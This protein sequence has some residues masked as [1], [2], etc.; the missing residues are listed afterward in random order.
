VIIRKSF[1]F[2]LKINETT[3]NKLSQVAG[4]CRFVWNKALALQIERL[5][6]KEKLLP[7]TQISKQLTEW[8]KDQDTLFLSET[9]FDSQQQKLRDLDR[10]FR[11]GF[12]KERDKKI[13]R[14]KK[15]G[16]R[17]SFRCVG[18]KQFSLNGNQVRIP[19]VGWIRFRKSREIEG[20]PKNITVSKS[21]EHWF[22]S[23]QTEI[24]IND[25]I[26]PASQVVGID[27]GVAKFA[28][29]SSGEEVKPLNS[30]RTLEKKLV[31]EQRKLSRK[32][33]FSNNWKKQKRKIQRIHAK[34]VDTRKDFLHKESTKIASENQAVIMEDLKV[35][36]MSK[37][38]KGT[39]ESPGKNVNAK[40]GL[41]KSI[42][43]Q[44]WYEFRRQIGYKLS[45][46][47]GKLI[48]INPQYTSQKC[49]VCG[50]ISKDNR[51]SQSKFLCVKCNHSQNADY[52][53]SLNIL[54][55]GH[56]V[57][58]CGDIRPVTA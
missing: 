50:H 32:I 5:E 25:P 18:P 36:N 22:V 29:L 54:A 51:K 19:K 13:P 26:H 10:A 56:T 47:G 31:K 48:L 24:E 23:I 8:R 58:A 21:G 14:F 2:R 4:S 16:Q 34:I 12:S 1:K 9:T 44:G 6:A 55:V 28:M 53:A 52:N 42:L 20:T 37:S 43:D 11:D 17:D 40:S 35:S 33:K 3:S 39:L 15:K 41:N 46:L 38:A 27:M 57:L 30:F 7:Y 49:S 45:W